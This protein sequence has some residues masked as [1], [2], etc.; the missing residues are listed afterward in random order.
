[1]QPNV[2]IWIFDLFVL[3]SSI[4]AQN[5]PQVPE[6]EVKEH[7]TKYEYR[8]PMRDGV[9]LFTSIYDRPHAL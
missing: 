9:H 4:A 1:M 5:P 3:V 8:I 6:F 7:Y 2:R